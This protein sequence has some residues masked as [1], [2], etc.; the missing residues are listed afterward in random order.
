MC[1]EQIFGSDVDFLV[2]DY[3][4]TDANRYNLLFH[5][6]FRG[7]LI[8]GRPAF[9][10]WRVQEKEDRRTSILKQLEDMGMSV[11]FGETASVRHAIPDTFGLSIKEI[12]AMP[13]YVRN[14]KC[15]GKIESGEPFCEEEKFSKFTCPNRNR[16]TNWHPGLYVQTQCE[17]PTVYP[18]FKPNSLFFLYVSAK[19]L[20]WMVTQWHYF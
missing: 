8:Q 6:G 12:A 20:R 3:S 1:S 2:W 4:L 19:H 17:Q 7:G 5:F 11:F 10:A 18:G 14:F 16:R 13:E 15:Q 9:L